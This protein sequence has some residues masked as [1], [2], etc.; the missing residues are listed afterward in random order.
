MKGNKGGTKRAALMIWENCGAQA[1][2]FCPLVFLIG[3]SLN[4]LMADIL[5]YCQY[6]MQHIL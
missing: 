1:E 3:R 4:C 5:S 2:Q 6:V